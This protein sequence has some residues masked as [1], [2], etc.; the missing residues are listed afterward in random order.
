M[1][2]FK[3][4]GYFIQ[5]AELGS[6]SRAAERLHIAQPSLS[7]QMR[8][9]EEELGAPL[10]IRNGRGMQLTEVGEQ[11]RLR[12][13]GPLRQVGHALNEIRALPSEAAGSVILGLPPTTISLLGEPL[14]RRV[15]AA[16]PKIA[17]HVVEASSGHL[18][19]WLQRGQL[20]AA[21]LYGPATPPGLN[22]T[23]LLE[24]ELVL[25]GP[26]D[27]G[28]RADQPVRFARLADLPLV[29]P[30]QMHG[31]RL[32][33]DALAARGM[34]ALNVRLQVDSL[35][36]IKD[37]VEAGMGYTALPRASC[38]RELAARRLVY[39]PIANPKPTRLLFFAMQPATAS[40][41]AVLQIEDLL[42]RELASLADEGRWPGL[43]TFQV[44]DA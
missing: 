39:A 1:A 20:D 3:R 24:D 8:L 27:C 41:R 21:V 25:L 13:T 6:L 37:L 30:G 31:L 4:L 35:Q 16:A 15:A 12:I 33:L 17:L 19:D 36:L 10:F 11:L 28:L 43:R 26:A 34:C 29:L 40:P 5:I 9:L 23:K 44:G 42:R 14:T 32:T 18:L 7:R 22:A 2:D 38:L